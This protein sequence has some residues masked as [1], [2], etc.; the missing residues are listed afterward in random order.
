[1]KTKIVSRAWALAAAT[2]LPMLLLS[3]C[4][5]SDDAAPP[6]VVAVADTVTVSPQQSADLLANDTLG[7]AQA[8]AGN[9]S[10]SIT[11]GTLPTGVSAA[12]GT[13]TAAAGSPPGRIDITYTICENG[14]ANNCASAS[15]QITV[16]APVIAAVNDSFN[17]SAGQS[18]DVL[19]N[20]SLDGAPATAATVT[21]AATGTL[22]AGITLAANGMLAVDATAATGT[23]NI[24]YSMCETA[25]PSNCANATAAVVVVLQ[26]TLTGRA[27]DASTGAG[28]NGIGVAIGAT[29]ATTDSSGN[30]SVS[31]AGLSGRIS[32]TFSGAGYA[33]TVRV[34]DVV[35]G[36]TTDVQARLV[37][38]AASVAVNVAT[39]GTATVAGSAAQVTLPANGVQRADGSMPSGDMTVQLTPLNPAVDSSV[40]PGNFTTAVGGVSTP[41]ES[42]GAMSVTLSDSSGAA[43]N[44]SPGQTATVRIPLS[45]RSATPPATVP[46]YYFD[47]ATGVWVEEGTATLAGSGNARYYEGTVT[48]F[49]TWNADQVYNTVRVSGCVVDANGTRVVGATVSADGID[50]SGT[51]SVTTDSSGNF[52]LPMRLGSQATVAGY[53]AGMLTNTVPAGP[54][55]V[56]STLPDCLTLGQA[57]AGV[58]MKLTWGQLPSDLDSHLFAPDGAEVYYGSQGSLTAAPFANL[59]VDD[60][61]SFGPEVVTLTRL[62]VGTYKYSVHNYSG[63]SSGSITASGARVELNVPG[64]AVELIT[65]PSGETSN[66]NWWNLF[67]MD[68]DA[69]CNITVRR[70]ATFSADKPAAGTAAATYCTP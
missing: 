23:Y 26:N 67:E 54:Y 35:A 66:T 41:I 46:L 50:Y 7:G 4:G 33:Q 64:R 31:S 10:F 17:L 47:N 24:A 28:I 6:A 25:A 9:V 60:T 69:S 8:T 34:A 16:V 63:Y 55:S 42:F 45:T 18:G 37:P 22:P 27:V 38:V 1:M 32:V 2:A 59:D 21:I 61:S 13:V 14:N 3:A 52:V 68:V 56:D 29:T 51:S 57:G 19:A 58:T 11:G 15:A 49:T 20:D 62:M 5:G 70:I 39:G 53:S 44:L 43:L 36:Q 30:F 65:P 48:H 40:M 12:N